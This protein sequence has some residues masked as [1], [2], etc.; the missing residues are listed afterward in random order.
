MRVQGPTIGVS[1]LF[2]ESL[3]LK[4]EYQGLRTGSDQR[5][6]DFIVSARLMY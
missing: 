5:G 1:H 4:A 6:R 2:F 3:L